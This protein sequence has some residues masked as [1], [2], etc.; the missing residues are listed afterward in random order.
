MYVAAADPVVNV[1]KWFF[2]DLMHQRWDS[3][4]SWQLHMRK[5]P[6]W[7]FQLKVSCAPFLRV[8]H[9]VHLGLHSFIIGDVL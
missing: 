3:T 4:Y 9:Q 5:S 8:L 7:R 1:R 2:E 6:V